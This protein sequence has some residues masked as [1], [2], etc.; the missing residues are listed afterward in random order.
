MQIIKRGDGISATKPDGTGIVYYLFD[1]YEIH[2]NEIPAQTVQ[3]W[4]HHNTIEEVIYVVDGELEVRW[5]IGGEMKTAVVRGGD[6]VRAGDTSHTI[7]NASPAVT[8]FLVF[9]LI[10]EGRNKRDIFKADK[11][12]DDAQEGSSMSDDPA[13]SAVG[14][15]PRDGR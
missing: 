11:H 2:Y 1:E 4:H 8:R 13:R 5:T 6:I 14:S 7:V 10:L 15:S 9:R 3:P 12:Y